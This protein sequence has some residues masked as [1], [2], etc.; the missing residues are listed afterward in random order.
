MSQKSAKLGQIKAAGVAVTAADKE[1]IQSEYKKVRKEWR[2]RKR[3]VKD[4]L[5]RITETMEKHTPKSMGE[6]MG[7]ET[8]ED[9]NVIM[10][11]DL[12]S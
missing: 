1:K 6:D 10:G 4:A 5:E 3:M 7:I 8:D 12:V 11:E 9:W 2:R